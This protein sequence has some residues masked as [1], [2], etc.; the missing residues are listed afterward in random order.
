MKKFF[1]IVG[2]VL[3]I[4]FAYQK[5]PTVR[6]ALS[7]SPCNTPL[8][9]KIGSIDERFNLTTDQVLSDT[10][11]AADI[12]NNSSD[13]P[14]FVYDESGKVTINLIYDKRQELSTQVNQLQQQLDNDKGNLDPQ[15]EE[16]KKKSAAF[17]QKAASLKQD[18]DYWNSR[19]GAPVDEYNKLKDRQKE[20]QTEAQELNQLARTLNQSAIDY[21]SQIGQ[22]NQTE[23]QLNQTLALKPEEG[24]YNGNDNSISIYFNNSQDELIHTIAHELGHARGLDHNNNIDSVMYPSSTEDI[25]LSPEDL[26]SLAE[27]CKERSDLELI[28]DRYADFIHLLETK[29]TSASK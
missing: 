3:I 6:H 17:D 11:R 4:F 8:T 5:V 21:N 19:G 12:W 1:I 7:Y 26:A 13:K 27:V 10:K 20:L 23:R 15:I 28:I 9:Y 24:L 16:Y 14:L 2:I 18:I 22:L 25:T 29:F